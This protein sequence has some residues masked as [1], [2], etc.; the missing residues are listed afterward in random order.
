M[1][2]RFAAPG[3]YPAL[4]RIYGQYIDT[5][6]TFECA[7]PSEEEFGKRIG[8]AAEFYP[9]L[10][11][12]EAGK[13]V[14]YAYGHRQMERE[15]YQWNAELSI[16]LDG[17]Y[18]SKGLGKTLYALLIGL[19]RLQGIKTVYGGVTVPHPKSEGLHEAMGFQRL[20][21]YHSTGYKCGRWHDVVWFE[22]QI[23]PYD[24]K[25]QPIR[26]IGAVPKDAVAALFR[27]ALEDVASL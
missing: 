7:L 17:A 18:T 24:S 20:G 5:P 12:E 26:P 11:C 9:C 4:L 16:Y 23:A 15:A 10:V 25:P 14:G 8:A 22:K 2:I 1:I 27:K 19:L 13:V 3:D 21:T 6:V